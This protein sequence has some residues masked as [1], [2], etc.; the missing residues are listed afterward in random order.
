MEVQVYFISPIQCSSRVEFKPDTVD[1]ERDER[2]PVAAHKNA[3]NLS[4]FT[5]LKV[6][7]R[8]VCE[9]VLGHSLAP[10]A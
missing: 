4:E 1:S 8:V 7:R 2:S 10:L 9:S 3:C 5:R 6:T